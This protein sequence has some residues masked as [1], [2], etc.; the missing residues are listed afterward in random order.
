MRNLRLL[1]EYDGTDFV[2]WQIQANGR[3]VQGEIA[4]A[5][6]RVLQEQVNL[7]GAG[8]TDAGVHARGQVANFR[9]SNG[10]APAALLSALNG[11]LPPDIRVRT[12]EDVPEAFHARFDARGRRYRYFIGRLPR[13]IG[14][15]Y[16]W[17]LRRELDLPVLRRIAERIVGDHDFEAFC[18][19]AAEVDHYRCIVVSAVW[20]EG[21][22][23]LVFD[24]RANRFLH[25]MV[26]ALVG[27]MVDVGRGHT[28][29][30]EF[31]AILAGRDRTRVGMAAPAHGLILEEVLYL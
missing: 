14:R 13:A 18:K 4:K 31:V 20:E 15:Q 7:I 16:Q 28:T 24:I 29:E 21:D 26:R 1:L 10:I 23:L 30:E 2:G 9:T 11:L 19:A 25:G 22:G 3:S 27:T 17:S 12:L 5:L 6:G 8:R